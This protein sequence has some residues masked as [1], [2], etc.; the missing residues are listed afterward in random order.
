LRSRVLSCSAVLALAICVTL[1]VSAAPRSSS[2]GEASLKGIVKS[3]LGAPLEGVAVSARADTK[4]ITTTVFTGKDGTYSFPPLPEGNYQ[5][6]AQAIGFVAD[7]AVVS[8]S[9]KQIARKNLTLKPT[10]DFSAQLTSVEWM[11]SLPA[12]TPEDRRAKRLL[13]INCNTCHQAGMAVRNR[14]DSKGWATIL[15]F[16]EHTGGDGG[17]GRNALPYIHSY[18]G[19]ILAYLN[20]V[21]GPLSLPLKF[22]P[23]PRPSGEATQVVFTEYDVAPGNLPDGP[24]FDNGSDWSEGLPSHYESRSP[25]D[26]VADRE[27]NV[28]FTDQA[29]PGRT[30]GKLDT[31]TGHVTNYTYVDKDNVPMATHDIAIDQ[32]GDIWTNVSPYDRKA[33]RRT[34]DGFFVRFNPKEEKFHPF[35]VPNDL[36]PVGSGLLNIDSKGHVWASVSGGA[37]PVGTVKETR[38][39]RPNLEADY[40]GGA[41]KLD[42]TT[43]K[44]T[45]FKAVNPAGSYYGVIVDAKDN[46]WFI[47]PGKERTNVIDAATG[48]ITEVNFP[49]LAQDVPYTD[50]DRKL[51]ST[52]DPGPQTGHPWHIGARRGAADK[53][54]NVIWYGGAQGNQLIKVDINTKQVRMYPMPYAH[55]FP[56]AVAVDNNHKVWVTA[57]ASDR[58]YR[59]DPETEKFTDFVLPT[60]GADVRFLD[61]DNSTGETVIWMP[62]YGASKIAKMEFRTPKQ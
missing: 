14:F 50:E 40:P 27:G 23:L 30:L 8:I 51:A 24:V 54:G 25:H 61:I 18:K 37:K 38:Y 19:E 4:T 17:I 32:N 43:G 31:R 47:H 20:K 33:G 36:P 55:S 29:T 15:D 48:T 41:I 59:F 10:T 21:R 56:Y 1:C 57:T 62:Y 9:T 13:G 45:F 49:L 42:P 52:Y 16:M 12:A 26:A 39:D 3:S 6:W 53:S 7:R 46:A 60:R 44:Y 5:L 28:W 22:K 34:G 2:S 11:D 35:P 58:I